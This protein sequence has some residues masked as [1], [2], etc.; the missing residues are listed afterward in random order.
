MPVTPTYPG[1]YIQEVPSGVR[2]ITSVA[3][4]IAAFLGRTTKGPINKAVRVL[5]LS[6]FERQF[7][8]PYARS[9]LATSVQQFFNNGG[10]DCYVVRLAN[11]PDFA[12]VTLQSLAAQE[13]L[14]VKAKAEGLW[15]NTVRMEIDY[16]TSNPDETFNM[17][18][19]QEE[20]GN[21]VRTEKF[22]NLSMDTSSARYAPSF[23]SQS[24]ELITLEL[25]AT[26]LG[27]PTDAASTYNTGTFAGTS[28]GRRPLG[29]TGTDVLS[30]LNTLIGAGKSKFQISIN[31][32][33]YVTV[34]LSTDPIPVGDIP[35]V[36]AGMIND[37]LAT[38]SPVET[39]S[40]SIAD[41][42]IGRMLT[43][44]STSGDLSSVR[45][46]RATSEDISVALMLGVD[47]GGIEQVRWSNFRPAPTA[48]LLRLGDPATPGDMTSINTVTALAQSVITQITIDGESIDF[49]GDYNSRQFWQ[50]NYYERPSIYSGGGR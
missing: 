37:A 45:V 35:T 44:T 34:D 50:R 22:T 9:S 14:D 42:G 6:D 5:S 10:T 7:G 19:I 46:K 27:D 29:T 15:A 40:C 20:A 38:L 23:V 11:D 13:V 2:T 12:S 49:I 17:T 25:S 4:S 21:V 47:Q 39:V 30:T 3:T 26:G 28:Y 18:V 8:E 31:G 36:I 16:D 1:V 33:A 41:P 32:S 24:S 48:S 43:I